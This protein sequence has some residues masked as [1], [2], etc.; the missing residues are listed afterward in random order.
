MT[1]IVMI[2]NVFVRFFHEV[3]CLQRWMLR[4]HDMNVFQNYF[5]HF[6][7]WFQQ[8]VSSFFHITFQRW[9]PYCLRMNVLGLHSFQQRNSP[10]ALKK[11]FLREKKLTSISWERD[12]FLPSCTV[13]VSSLTTGLSVFS[14]LGFRICSFD[15]KLLDS[16]STCGR[17]TCSEPKS[18]FHSCF[19]EIF[20]ESRGDTYT[21]SYMT[22]PVF[23]ITTFGI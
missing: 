12:V 19:K 11:H 3:F 22:Y 6:L 18:L 23:I 1:E 5:T 21:D 16:C 8:R 14:R 7:S 2:N 10:I 13:F 20:G 9:D 4:F 15:W 17:W